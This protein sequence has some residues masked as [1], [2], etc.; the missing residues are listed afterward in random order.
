MYKLLIA[1]DEAFIRAGLQNLIEWEVYGIEIVGEADNGMSAYMNIKKLCPDLVLLDISMPNMD[2]LEL[3]DICSHMP[4]PPKFIV[5]SGYNNFQYVQK[6]MQL[7]AIN[8]LLKPVDQDELI[9]TV[10]SSVKLLDDLKAHQQQFE[11][12]LETLRNGVLVRVLHN[13][14]EPR[15]L[16]EKCQVLGISFH[17]SYMRAGILRPVPEKSINAESNED[18]AGTARALPLSQALR[19]CQEICEQLCAC[20]V[21]CDMDDSIGVIFKDQTN[22]LSEEDFLNTLSQCARKLREALGLSVLY[23]IG[24]Q[25]SRLQELAASYDSCVLKIEKQFLLGDAIQDRI[26]SQHFQPPMNYEDFL[27]YLEQENRM[28]IRETI[29]LYFVEFLSLDGEQDIDILKYYLIELVTYVLHSK[30]MVAF[31]Q[32]EITQKKEEAFTIISRTDSILQLEEKLAAFFLGLIEHTGGTGMDK[33][34]SFMI[35]TALGYV[36]NHY[37]DGNLSLKTLAAHMEVNAAYLGR[38][39]ARETGEYFNEYL[40]RIRI[41]KAIHLLTATTWK[42]GKIATSVGFVN[43]SYFFTIFKKIT[44]QS[45]G[46]YRS[47]HP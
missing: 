25:V 35:Q 28:K 45:P 10:I 34:Y 22:Q 17:C 37:A 29:H 9:Q 20:Y 40:N 27:R 39:F 38:E 11:E 6:S 23:G 33:E 15:E 24:I 26:S 44:G 19:I 4:H 21:A 31:S 13:R 2:G 46:D 18:K 14:I 36:N 5:L 42:T 41:G 12:S 1:D 32:Q 47:T 3:M 43:N 30:Y 8:Y 7:G 16:R